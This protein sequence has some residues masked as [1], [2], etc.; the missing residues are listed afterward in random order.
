MTPNLEAL[1]AIDEFLVIDIPSYIVLDTRAIGCVHALC[2]FVLGR[3]IQTLYTVI[4]IIM[5][6]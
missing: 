5:I 6:V 2:T 3:S 4:I 1:C